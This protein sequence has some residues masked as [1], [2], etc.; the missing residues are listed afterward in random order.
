VNTTNIE[1]SSSTVLTSAGLER[2]TNEGHSTG[3]TAIA[4]PQDFIQAQ[5][6]TSSGVPIGVWHTT[7]VM[8]STT[9]ESTKEKPGIMNRIKAKFG[10]K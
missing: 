8:E 3:T 10:H 2:T 7:T 9:E 5:P 1:S 6:L 4:S